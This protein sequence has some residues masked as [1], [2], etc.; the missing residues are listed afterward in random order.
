MLRECLPIEAST[1]GPSPSGQIARGGHDG[2]DS[3]P[4]TV[5]HY[6]PQP[7]QGSETTSQDCPGL[8]ACPPHPPPPKHTHR[9]NAPDWLPGCQGQMPLTTHQSLLP[10]PGS[11]PP[12]PPAPGTMLDL[13]PS[14]TSVE[15]SPRPCQS[16][17]S[18]VL[19]PSLPQK[20]PSVPTKTTLPDSGCHSVQLQQPLLLFHQQHSLPQKPGV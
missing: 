12:R 8:A 16:S 3:S 17:F 15:Q 7:A 1:T 14:P 11:V 20:P 6:R 10:S 4:Q 13:G 18:L 2:A 19:P 9:H 5:G